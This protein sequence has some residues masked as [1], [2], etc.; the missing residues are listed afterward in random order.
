MFFVLS[1][2]LVF[3]RMVFDLYF[4]L[5][6][7]R[8]R[9]GFGILSICSSSHKVYKTLYFPDSVM[10]ILVFI[11]SCKWLCESLTRVL[12]KMYI[13]YHFTP[14]TYSHETAL[15]SGQMYELCIDFSIH[16]RVSYIGLVLRFLLF[17][18]TWWYWKSWLKIHISDFK[19]YVL[20]PKVLSEKFQIL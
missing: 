17:V 4:C 19:L 7:E 13:R 15:D 2:Y 3:E 18:F 12:W 10:L 8:S 5:Q 14:L 6:E 11:W 20:V 1:H 9:E 16:L